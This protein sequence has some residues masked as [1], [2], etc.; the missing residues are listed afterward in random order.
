MLPEPIR[1][2]IR[3]FLAGNPYRGQ[4]DDAVWAAVRTADPAFGQA[5]CVLL[6][7]AGG[8]VFGVCRKHLGLGADAEDVFQDAVIDLIR[9]P[10]RRVATFAQAR[11]W[12]CAVARNKAADRLKQRNATGPLADEA[13]VS[14]ADPAPDDRLDAV[15]AAVAALKE[16]YRVP[17]QLAAIDG[18]TAEAIAGRLGIAAEAA[19][20]RVERARGMVLRTL[21]RRGAA[22]RRRPAVVPPGRRLGAGG[23]G[24]GV[25][26]GDDLGRPADLLA[27]ADPRREGSGPAADPGASRVDHDRPGRPVPGLP[28]PHLVTGRPDAN[29]R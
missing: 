11:A 15:L 5:L 2:L 14:S 20:K 17:F 7:R 19:Q 21:A 16:K 6:E 9:R 8:P 23:R 13:V 27:T 18:L 4:P 25:R 24:R 26:D 12:L 28:R 1:H 3:N 10:P 29:H 22:L